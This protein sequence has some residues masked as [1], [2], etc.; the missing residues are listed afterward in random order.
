MITNEATTQNPITTQTY[1]GKLG[2]DQYVHSYLDYQHSLNGA[3]PFLPV[4][5]TAGLALL[6][7]FRA[8]VTTTGSVTSTSGSSNQ[9]TTS[10]KITSLAKSTSS[11]G[12]IT[13]SSLTATALS[14]STTTKGNSGHNLKVG[15]ELGA[16]AVIA[17][18]AM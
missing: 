17:Y 11:T 9:A 4:K 3:P 7:A 8:A 14:V 15:W 12:S 5:I 6:S 13:S 1:D 18:A 2:T 10:P 16:A